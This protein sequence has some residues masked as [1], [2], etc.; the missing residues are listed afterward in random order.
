[1]GGD[2][3]RPAKPQG[4]FVTKESIQE[5]LVWYQKILQLNTLIQNERSI[6]TIFGYLMD[7]AIEAFAITTQRDDRIE[8]KGVYS[9]PGAIAVGRA[10]CPAGPT[11][12]PHLGPQGVPAL[13]TQIDGVPVVGQIGV[14][15][16][17]HPRQQQVYAGRLQPGEPLA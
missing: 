17:A 8:L 15:M 16:D 4:G 11:M 13:G 9:A 12:G 2:S 5:R 10:G 7:D 3:Q 6:D 14:A 1:M